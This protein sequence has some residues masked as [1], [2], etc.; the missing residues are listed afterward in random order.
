MLFVLADG[1]A[2]WAPVERVVCEQAVAM[3]DRGEPVS[4]ELG[5]GQRVAVENAV[6]VPPDEVS[7]GGPVVDGPLS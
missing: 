6:C 2:S 1:T 7:E 5:N 4:I 3:L